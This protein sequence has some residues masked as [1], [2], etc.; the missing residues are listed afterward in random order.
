MTQLFALLASYLLIP[1][2]IR[3]KVK[4]SHTLLITA[5]CL[6]VLSGIGIDS[7]K[8]IFTGLWTNPSS[9]NTI[10][11]VAMVSILGGLMNHYGLLGRIVASLQAITQSKKIS[12]VAIPALIGVLIIPGGAMLSAPF[13]DSIGQEVGM[14]PARRA[15]VNLVFRHLAMF[16]MPYSTSLLVVGA[17]L[18][19]I[20]IYKM[21]SLNLAMVV[22]MLAIGNYLLMR[23]VPGKKATPGDGRQARLFKLVPELLLYSSPI[24]ICVLIN[25][26]FGWPFSLAMVA[27]LGAV[28]LL[29]DKRD[30]LKVCIKSFNGNVVLIVAVVLIMKDIILNME[31]LMALLRSL[32]SL[33]NG[34]VT[35]VAV[36]FLTSLLIGYATGYS[37]AALAVTLPMISE[38]GASLPM[39][40]VFAYFAF[41]SSFVGYFFSPLHLCQAFTLQIMGVTTSELYREYKRYAPLLLIA[42]LTSGILM[43]AI[44][45]R[46]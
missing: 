39:L 24:Y 4:L 43:I 37:V 9:L 1:I 29:S 10:L 38:L 6:G 36:I 46:L 8:E 45:S 16:L 17:A 2:L 27:S 23:D 12:M 33:G 7:L 22:S 15:A 21:I 5:V 41:G 40:H 18:P 34:T 25:L 30:F 28:F 42:L 31:G 3:R 26:I 11:V 13:V 35:A 44:A 19:Q 14:K 32:F 20:D